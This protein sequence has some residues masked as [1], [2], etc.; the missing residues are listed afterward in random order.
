MTHLPYIL[1]AYGLTVAVTGW[2]SISA[3]LRLK[4]AQKRLAALE[5]SRD[6]KRRRETT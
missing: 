6:G 1:A 5:A 3:V 4:K 2:L